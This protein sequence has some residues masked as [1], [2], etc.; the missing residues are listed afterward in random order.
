MSTPAISS[1]NIHSCNFCPPVYLSLHCV[2]IDIINLLVCIKVIDCSPITTTFDALWLRCQEGCEVLSVCSVCVLARVSQKAHVQ[3]SPWPWLGPLLTVLSLT[4]CF[5]VM[6]QIQIQA[7]SLRRSEL[8]TETHY[9]APLNYKPGGEV[10]IA[11]CLVI[12][13]VKAIL[14][15]C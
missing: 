15:I 12:Y 8:F 5:L 1:V 14:L 4:S 2:V 9:M 13:L 3:T 6:G 11:D 7:C 10:A